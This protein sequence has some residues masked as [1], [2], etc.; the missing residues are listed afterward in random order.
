MKILIVGSGAIGEM[1][2]Q[3]IGAAGGHS[4]AFCDSS[5]ESAQRL[6]NAFGADEIYADYTEA[7][8]KSCA[9]AVIVCTPNFLHAPV[10]IEALGAGCDVLCEKPMAST[11][12]QAAAMQKA[13]EASGRTLM[14]GYI[15]RMNR[16]LQRL[17]VVLDSGE[18]GRIVSARVI[19][20]APETLTYAKSDYRKSYETGGGIIYDYSHELDYCRLFFGEAKRC[21][22]FKGLCLKAGKTCDDNADMMIEY[23]SGVTLQLHMDYIQ[24]KGRGTGRGIEIVCEKGFAACDFKNVIVSWYNGDTT[25]YSFRPDGEDLYSRNEV[26]TRQF[27]TFLRACGGEKLPYVTGTDGMRVIELCERLY[28]SANSGLVKEL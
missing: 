6:A 5:R 24:E 13:A 15:M 19:L 16:A 10:T 1:H 9:Q 20:A 21:V 26:F 22:C 2:A 12:Q 11:L 18:L 17:K 14:I 27:E 28:D 4:L 7:I 25:N 3:V 23:K 8:R